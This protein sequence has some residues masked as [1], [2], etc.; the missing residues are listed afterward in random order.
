M[1]NEM[2]PSKLIVEDRV[3]RAGMPNYLFFS[4][5][6]RD[7]ESFWPEIMD[8]LLYPFTKEQLADKLVHLSEIIRNGPTDEHRKEE[9]ARRVFAAESTLL[10][11]QEPVRKAKLEG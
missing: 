11:N 9:Q 5:Q 7:E 3:G 4:L 6:F 8:Y 2:L 10:A 1:P